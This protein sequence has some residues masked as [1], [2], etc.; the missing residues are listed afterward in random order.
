MRWVGS[1]FWQCNM[2]HDFVPFKVRV[3]E[4][5]DQVLTHIHTPHNVLSKLRTLC[6]AVFIFLLDCMWR[7][8]CIW[9]NLRG[10]TLLWKQSSLHAGRGRRD[11]ESRPQPDWALSAR[12]PLH[13]PSSKMP[14]K[15]HIQRKLELRRARPLGTERRWRKCG[16]TFIRY[17]GQAAK[18]RCTNRAGFRAQLSTLWKRSLTKRA[19]PVHSEE[20]TQL[21]PTHALFKM[22]RRISWQRELLNIAMDYDSP[23]A[24][25]LW[26]QEC[27]TSLALPT[28]RGF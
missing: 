27:L 28:G 25:D 3:W 21:R 2:H 19:R 7:A 22:D 12:Q 6:Q 1:T 10:Q 9:T 14:S 17:D 26:K 24:G 8:G 23:F 18:L 13:P 5:H 20:K 11:V 4:L 15:S 16:R